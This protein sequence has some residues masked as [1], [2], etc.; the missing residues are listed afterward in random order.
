LRP[1]HAGAVA[2]AKQPSSSSLRYAL[3]TGGE[4]NA[5]TALVDDEGVDLTFKRRD[6]TRTLDVQVKARFSD[7]AGSKAIRRLGC[8]MADVYEVSFRPRKD[9]YML[10]DQRPSR[11]HRHRVAGAE[12]GPRR[13]RHA[14]QH[15][16]ATPHPIP[17]VGQARLSRQVVRPP[18]QPGGSAARAACDRHEP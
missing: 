14:R 17:G 11:R 6:G 2:R 18:L 12:R 10:Y 7:R 13:G 1:H 9:L 5:L 16:R 4:L 8:F 3:A 15:P